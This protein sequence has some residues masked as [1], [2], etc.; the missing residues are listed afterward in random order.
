MSSGSLFSLAW[1]AWLLYWVVSAVRVKAT[2]RRES[3]FSRATYVVPSV[4]GALML[5]HSKWTGWLALQAI[6]PG[7]ASYWIGVVLLFAGLGFACWARVIIGTN[8][9]GNVTLKSGHELIRTGPY[10]H[11]RHPIYTGLITA[12]LGTAIAEG[13]VRSLV[14]AGLISAA[15]IYKL[16]VEERML[17]ERFKEEYDR[18]RKDVAALIPG[19]F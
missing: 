6:P 13:A 3:L 7:P 14:G 12:L 5:V 8:W 9:S 11:V 2:E 15:F 17:S 18:Y 10:A 16:G 1:I 19:V 4:I